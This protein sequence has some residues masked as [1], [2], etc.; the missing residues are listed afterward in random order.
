MEQLPQPLLIAEDFSFYQQ[1]LPGL[2]LLLGTGSG[3][4]LHAD[5]FD[6]DETVLEVGLAAD[7][8]LLWLE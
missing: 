7:E 1:H 4:P 3:I 2:F 5:T 6:F 8:A